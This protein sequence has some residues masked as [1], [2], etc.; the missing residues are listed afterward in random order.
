MH[1]PNR[2]NYVS[3]LTLHPLF[4]NTSPFKTRDLGNLCLQMKASLSLMLAFLLNR[5]DDLYF[6][7]YFQPLVTDIF[8]TV[9]LITM[10]GIKFSKLNNDLSLRSGNTI[11]HITVVWQTEDYSCLVDRTKVLKN[12]NQALAQSSIYIYIYIYIYIGGQHTQ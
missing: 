7:W 2:N 12:G 10:K 4:I 5:L 8:Q 11:A 1:V 6:G 9:D 3:F